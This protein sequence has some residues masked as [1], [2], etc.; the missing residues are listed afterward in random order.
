MRHFWQQ[1]RILVILHVISVRM[2]LSILVNFT[3]LTNSFSRSTKLSFLPSF[4][5][6]ILSSNQPSL[7]LLPV[8][9]EVTLGCTIV[10]MLNIFYFN[11]QGMITI[12]S[13][14]DEYLM[15][16]KI[17]MSSIQIPFLHSYTAIAF[18]FIYFYHHHKKKH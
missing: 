4:S 8:K 11:V 2:S 7:N 5:I 17:C 14:G 15:H 16:G 1:V 18:S 10:M 13:E 6:K 12:E 3:L 9:T